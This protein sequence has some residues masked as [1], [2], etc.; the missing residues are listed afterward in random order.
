MAKKIDVAKL[1]AELDEAVKASDA[2]RV[3]SMELQERYDDAV[4]AP[5]RRAFVGKCFK[6]R[7]NYSSPQKASDFWYD[8]I[9]VVSVDGAMLDVVQCFIDSQGTPKMERASRVSRHGDLPTG[10]MLIPR[11]EYDRAFKRVLAKLRGA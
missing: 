6:V 7:D 2:A 10:W 5:K 1:K 9:R 3:R 8:Y 4:T 11:A